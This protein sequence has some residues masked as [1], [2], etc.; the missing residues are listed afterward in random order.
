MG[1]GKQNSTSLLP[2]NCWEPARLSKSIGVPSAL[3]NVIIF[4]FLYLLVLLLYML[5]VT[6]PHFF[7]NFSKLILFYFNGRRPLR[8][9]VPYARIELATYWVKASRPNQ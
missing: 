6:I 7:P 2:L 4:T 5:G 8:G 9:V 1:E 3:V